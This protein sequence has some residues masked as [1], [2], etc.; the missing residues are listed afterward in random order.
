MNIGVISLGCAKNQVDLEE[1]LAYLKRNDFNIVTSPEAADIIIVNTC[2]FIDSAK[3]ESI[4][5]IL[6]MIRYGKPVVVTGCLSTR[7]L[8]ELKEEI[9]EV[10]LWIPHIGNTAT[11]TGSEVAACGA[12]HHGASTGHI[13]AAVVAHAFNHGSSTA[14]SHAEAFT[15]A[16][17][18][19]HFA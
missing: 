8:D 7:Y 2:A 4:D 3:T 19:I 1:I 6:D 10:A 12:K 14:I 13:L 5:A 9:P 18:D 16:T 17:V 15:Y 11:H